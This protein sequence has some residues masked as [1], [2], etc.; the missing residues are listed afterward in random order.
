MVKHVL[1]IADLTKEEIAVIINLAADMKANKPKYLNALPR[2]SVCCIFEKPSLRTRVS[3]E[4]GCH[5]L[6][7]HAI[8]YNTRDSPMG[9]KETIEDTGIVLSRMTNAITARVMSRETLVKLASVATVPVINA[10]DDW[11]HPM[12]ML[13]DLLT[14]VEVRGSYEGMTLTFAGDLDNNMTFDLMRT[15][16][17]CG[18]NIR[19][20][21]VGDI[22]KA[23]TEECTALNLKSGGTFTF[24]ATV[25]EAVLGADVVYCDSWMSYGISKDKEAARIA[26]FL[27]F[28]VNAAV[29][30]K[31][32]PTAVFMN[33]LPAV[34]GMEQTAE[35]ID[36][37]QSVVFQQ[38]ENRV[39]SVKA[40][41]VFLVN[42]MVVVTA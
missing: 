22:P 4:V 38:A 39:H 5:E 35:V 27:P 6:G 20:A 31:A 8:Y 28:Q 23:V 30:A 34:R 26:A 3:L 17:V 36:G 12:Q 25:D 19:L 9:A 24:C 11:A 33:C 32:K 40:L 41:L 21:G 2:K 42:G 13:A 7:A 29:M 10:L 14:I 16:G 18:F 1:T 37:P 15:A